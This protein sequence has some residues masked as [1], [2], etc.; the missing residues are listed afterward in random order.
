LAEDA[1]LKVKSKLNPSSGLLPT[2]SLSDVPDAKPNW[3]R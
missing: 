2:M 3:P 1:P